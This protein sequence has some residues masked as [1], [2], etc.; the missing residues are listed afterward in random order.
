MAPVRSDDDAK[1]AAHAECRQL[2]ALAELIR[3]SWGADEPSF[4]RIYNA[5]FMPDGPI[6]QWR[7]FDEL[8]KRT[9]SPENAVQLWESFQ[10]DDVTET[11]RSL[12]VPTL[13]LHARHER[14]HP[15]ENAEQLKDLIEGSQLSALASNNHILQED[16]PAF[17]EFLATV[18]DFLTR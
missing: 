12:R 14:L 10:L 8:Q 16:E 9:T 17:A 6:E 5:R 13:I 4:Q 15:Y 18:D 2:D 11:A 1:L 7:A 3:V